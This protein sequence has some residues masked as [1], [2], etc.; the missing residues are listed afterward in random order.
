MDVA[1]FEEIETGPPVLDQQVPVPGVGDAIVQ[2]ATAFVAPAG[3]CVM[4][5]HLNDTNSDFVIYR[6]TSSIRA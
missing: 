6:I 3:E 4:F 2:P 1:A 5:N